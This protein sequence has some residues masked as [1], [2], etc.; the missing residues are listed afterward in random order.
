VLSKYWSNGVNDMPRRKISTGRHHSFAGWQSL[1]I[2]RLTNFPARVEKRTATGLM[3]C[4]VH[5]A[6]THQ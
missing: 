4:A 3:N 1:R 5:P 2:L 6:S